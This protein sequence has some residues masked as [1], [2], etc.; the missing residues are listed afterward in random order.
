MSGIEVKIKASILIL[1][2]PL[3]LT[4][5]KDIPTTPLPSVEKK[6]EQEQKELLPKEKDLEAQKKLVADYLE[7]QKTSSEF[8][9]KDSLYDE[10]YSFYKRAMVTAISPKSFSTWGTRDLKGI[11]FLKEAIE[12]NP[13]YHAAYYVLGKSY[14][15]TNDPQ[16]AQECFLKCIELKPK[17]QD[18]YAALANLYRNVGFYDDA[19]VYYN[20]SLSIGQPSAQ[21]YLGLGHTYLEKNDL[22]KA[23]IHY[24]KVLEFKEL[25]DKAYASL[26]NL[27]LK[28]G[29]LKTA[30]HYLRKSNDIW[31]IE[32]KAWIP[33]CE[34][35]LTSNNFY[36]YASLGRIY[37]YRWDYEKAI[38]YLEKAN[39]INER[40]FDQ[41]YELGMAYNYTTNFQKAIVLLEKAVAMNPNHYDA[42]MELGS[43]YNIPP[44]L[45]DSYLENYKIKPNYDRAIDLFVKAKAIRPDSDYPYHEL[46]DVYVNLE[47]YFR[48]LEEAKIALGRNKTASN[49]SKVGYVY[50]L[51]KDYANALENHKKALDLQD[52]PYYR[53]NVAR[54]LEALKKYDEALIVLELG[55]LKYKAKYEKS[56]L[57]S[58]IANI[59]QEKKGFT[60][61]IEHY[62]EVLNLY[63]SD[64]NAHFGIA[65]CHY[66]QKDWGL[67][68]QW[69]EKA[70]AIN[71]KSSASLHNIGLTLMHMESH[72]LAIDYFNKALAIDPDS[73]ESKEMIKACQ[74]A[75]EQKNYPAKL[76]ALSK[77]K[78]DI[79]V[80]AGLTLCTFEYDKANDLWITGIDETKHEAGKNI[81]SSKIYL[82]QGI[83]EKIAEDL[84]KISSSKTSIK[85]ILELFLYALRKRTEGIKEHSEGFYK[86]VAE[87]KGEFEKGRAKM[88][89]ADG[90]FTDGLSLLRGELKKYTNYFGPFANQHL[91]NSIQYYK[92]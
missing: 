16:K 8:D 82:A 51:M 3:M 44:Y 9:P 28:K 17:H 89:I 38:E 11:D 37:Y 31:E 85:Q 1:L 57:I 86:T 24:H 72:N 36:A 71:P 83:F 81:V 47:Q 54:D 4:C 34:K 23:E 30:W 12:V 27:S 66:A 2:L 41:Y 33:K 78:D 56:E 55:L 76:K 58:L 5:S 65:S 49:F 22:L 84:E 50:S 29:D 21:I 90:Y 60:E 42:T 80:L 91:T 88:Q 63:P 46:V 48:A 92:R 74:L 64:F 75:T 10:A 39:Q 20:K 77:R 14:E 25:N 87:Y 32:V 43:L 70:L 73:G 45:I 15:R 59:H 61:A 18:S 68:K 6:I 7:R 67:A 35:Y 13:H 53:I 19:L 40:E 26:A 62:H 79:G 69:W 52:R